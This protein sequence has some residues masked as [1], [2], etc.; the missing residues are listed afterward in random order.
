MNL[1][2]RRNKESTEVIGSAPTL[3]IQCYCTDKAA[4]VDPADTFLLV[5]VGKLW[6]SGAEFE[7][8]YLYRSPLDMD[9]PLQLNPKAG[10]CTSVDT[11]DDITVAKRF[12]NFK[13][14][15]TTAA[16][17]GGKVIRMEPLEIVVSR[18]AQE[19]GGPI[20]YD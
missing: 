20:P 2:K 3:N 19:T 13:E 14:A 7:S 12:D 4:D 9:K 11:T 6:I 8:K 15:V 1:F 10:L 18:D 17:C 16:Y 5:K